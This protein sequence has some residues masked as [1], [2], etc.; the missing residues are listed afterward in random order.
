MGSGRVASRGADRDPGEG[1]QSNG[2]S[3]W[4]TVEVAHTGGSAGLCFAG[5]VDE[6]IS[7]PDGT[8]LDVRQHGDVRRV[9]VHAP[10]G[11]QV[12]VNAD[13]VLTLN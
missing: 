2:R 6:R 13:G 7:R 10:G 9:T 5:Q 1:W 3:G 8:V 4:L 12:D 11:F